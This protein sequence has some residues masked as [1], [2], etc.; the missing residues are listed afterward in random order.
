MC[1]TGFRRQPITAR[2][3]RSKHPTRQLIVECSDPGVLVSLA[4]EFEIILRQVDFR[5]AQEIERQLS[6][7]ARELGEAFEETWRGFRIEVPNDGGRPLAFGSRDNL[8][9]DRLKQFLEQAAER[10]IGRFD[11]RDTLLLAQ[12][13]PAPETRE[14]YIRDLADSV[15][16][17]YSDDVHL[18]S[19]PTDLPDAMAIHRGHLMDEH[20]I[21]VLH[22][23][24]RDSSVGHRWVHASVERLQQALEEV[25]TRAEAVM[26]YEF[27]RRHAGGTHALGDVGRATGQRI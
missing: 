4:E 21:D 1:H 19:R 23:R 2:P 14:Q 18:L 5:R 26:L 9:D 27:S 11:M 24:A 20:V 6:D 25:D 13:G 8:D 12:D 3:G 22:A 16:F 10:G 7:L 15:G 17:E